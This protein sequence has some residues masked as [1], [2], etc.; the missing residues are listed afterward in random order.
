M[1]RRGLTT[2]LSPVAIAIGGLCLWS[3][4]PRPEWSQDFDIGNGL[5]LRVWS[6][7]DDDWVEANPP[8]VYYRIEAGAR[9]IVPATYL[10]YDDQHGHAF[11]LVTA[12][13]GRLVCVYE[14]RRCVEESEFLLMFDAATQ[15]SWPRMRGEGGRL[16]DRA[17]KWRTRYERL[18]AENPSLPRVAVFVE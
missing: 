10:Y 6:A 8:A 1:S 14:P 9:E 11:R 7:V 15:E 5:T 3:L 13:A 12:D 18:K 2:V 4:Q 17:A 16:T